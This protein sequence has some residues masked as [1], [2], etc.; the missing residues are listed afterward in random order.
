MKFRTDKTKGCH[1]I[2]TIS[3]PDSTGGYA[4]IVEQDEGEIVGCTYDSEG[5][6]ESES[7]RVYGLAPIEETKEAIVYVSG[8][9]VLPDPADADT[10]EVRDLMCVVY[11]ADDD[12]LKLGFKGTKLVS[13]EVIQ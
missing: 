3:G 6:E 8:R 13:A 5:V 7:T 1:K 11:Q 2:M 9:A 12:N 10:A 4:A